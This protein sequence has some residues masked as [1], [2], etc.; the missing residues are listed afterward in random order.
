MENNRPQ[1]GVVFTAKHGEKY[2]KGPSVG[3]W[4]NDN[5]GPMARG[6]VKGEYLVKLAKFLAQV[7]KNGDTLS[8]ALFKNG[9]SPQQNKGYDET[10]APKSDND[11]SAYDLSAEDIPF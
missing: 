7:V 3:L 9:P 11:E 1:Y 6:A 8:V 2:I 4:R 10:E 5:D